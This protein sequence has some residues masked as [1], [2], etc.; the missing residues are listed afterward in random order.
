MVIFACSEIECFVFGIE[1]VS[2]HIA[3]EVISTQ[4]SGT[5]QV[6]VLSGLTWTFNVI[7]KYFLRTDDSLSSVSNLM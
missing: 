4:Q 6:V 3:H 5:C 2:V 1:K 7:E